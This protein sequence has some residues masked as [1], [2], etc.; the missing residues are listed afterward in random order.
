VEI[1]VHLPSSFLS[2]NVFKQVNQSSL[3]LNFLC[4]GAKSSRAEVLHPDTFEKVLE[5][6]VEAK[7]ACTSNEQY[8]VTVFENL[9]NESK[10]E[11]LSSTN[12]SRYHVT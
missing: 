5:A 9:L 7:T 1:I 8:V 3:Q 4:I 11:T 6:L 10:I 12:T 2:L